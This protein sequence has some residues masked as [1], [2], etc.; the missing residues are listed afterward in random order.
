[1]DVTVFQSTLPRGER[2]FFRNIWLIDPTISIHAPARGATAFIALIGIF[3][4]FQSTLPRGERLESL[5]QI[6]AVDAISIHAPARGATY[7]MLHE[8][9]L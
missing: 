1:M 3:F 7:L 2:R 6:I 4:S 9:S 8:K 5:Y